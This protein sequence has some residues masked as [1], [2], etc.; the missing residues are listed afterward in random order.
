VALRAESVASGEAPGDLEYT[1]FLDQLVST[2]GIM[3]LC[4]L[5]GAEDSDTRAHAVGAAQAVL[6]STRVMDNSR[7]ALAEMTGG[8][9]GGSET[10]DGEVVRAIVA[11]GGCSPSVSQLLISADNSVAG[12]G[13]DFCASLV[14]PLL[15]QAA[16]T[17]SLPSEYDW[18][19]DNDGMGACREAALEIA[20][21]S[22]L[23]ALLSLVR[24][25]AKRP[26]ELKRSA[27]ETLAA[28]VLAVGEIGRAWAGGKYEEGLEIAGAP[29]KLKEA[30]MLL[31]EGTCLLPCF[32]KWNLSKCFSRFSSKSRLIKRGSARCRVGSPAIL[33]GAIFGVSLGYPCIQSARMCWNHPGVNDFLLGGSYHGTPDSESCVA[34]TTCVE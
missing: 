10:K 19:N 11:G 16:A 27:M 32:M 2:G 18:R 6:T 7:A 23:P 34:L 33:I 31:N 22:C 28:V 3:I 26:V 15:S 17:A 13:C 14:G 8:Q 4:T 9:P 29:A 5:I 20:T 24:E 25:H 21:G 1:S 12:M 30:L